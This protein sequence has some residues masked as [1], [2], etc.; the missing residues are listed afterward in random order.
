[1]KNF[2][3]IAA[4]NAINAVLTSGAL[5]VLNSGNFNFHSSA[6]WW[7]LGKAALSAVIAREATVWLPIVLKWSSTEAAPAPKP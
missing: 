5:A 6:G 1:M 2:L 3:L 4:K 7:N